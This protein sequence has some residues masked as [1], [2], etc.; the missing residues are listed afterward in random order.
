M[1]NI[2]IATKNAGKAKDFEQIFQPYGVK[3]K[4]LLDFPKIE[5]VEETGETFE[6]NAILKAEAISK[7]F[8][9]MVIADDSGVMIDALD[10][11]PGVYSARYAG[12]EKNDEANNEKVLKELANVPEKDRGAQFYCAIAVAQ[13][14]KPTITVNGICEGSIL[15]EGKGTNGFGYDPIFFVTS[16]GKSMAELTPEE[17]NTI[18]HRA[19]AMKKLEDQLTE[20]FHRS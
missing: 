17:K 20:F 19:S 6:E 11:R 3:V 15:F 1:E 2:I 7:K 4:T 18:S 14:G 12:E 5:D 13:P 9:E 10:G 16:M 8:N